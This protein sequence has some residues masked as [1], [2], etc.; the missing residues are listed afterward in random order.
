MIRLVAPFTACVAFVAPAL[1]LQVPTPERAPDG[2]VIDERMV[3]AA[4]AP[5]DVIQVLVPVQ[6]RTSVTLSPA[7]TE[8]DLPQNLVGW[9]VGA[10]GNAIAFAAS[11]GAVATVAHVVSS[12]PDGSKR[13][14]VFELNASAQGVKPMPPA[15]ANAVVASNDPSSGAAARERPPVPYLT[16]RM[17]YAADEARARTVAATAQRSA[18]REARRVARAAAAEA[19]EQVQ[20]RAVLASDTATV[21]RRCNF[22]WRGDQGVVPLAACETGAQTTFLWPGQVPAA[23]VFLV[24]ADG[25][26]QAVDQ[27]PSPDRPGLV[28]VPAT[29]QFWRVRRGALVADLFDAS[30]DPIGMDTGTGTLS[31]RVR[32][33]LRADAGTMP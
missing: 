19:Q 30:F 27:S 21:R 5:R 11:P 3:T 17:T 33:R 16:I 15:E 6:G 24:A 13:H 4:Y 8:F 20:A 18:A 22:M 31:P 9:Q 14:Y 7:E 29:S 26:E 25:S 1:A 2:R 23:A 28:V 10:A 32:T 12:L